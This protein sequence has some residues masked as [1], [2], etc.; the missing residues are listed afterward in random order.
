MSGI[1]NKIKVSARGMIHGALV[2]STLMMPK[3]EV[4]EKLR[5]R[6]VR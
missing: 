6:H 1:V 5:A 2:S 4:L 3:H